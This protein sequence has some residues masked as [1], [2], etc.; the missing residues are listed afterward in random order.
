MPREYVERVLKAQ[1]YEVA[2]ETPLDDAPRLSKRLDNRVLIKREDLQSVFSFKLRGA[3]NKIAGL[4]DAERARGVI[5][6]SAGNHAQ[7]VALAAAKLGVD[8]LIVMPETTPAIKS[9]AV[10]ALGARAVLHGSSYD[11][12]KQHALEI[13]DEE[14]RVFVHPFDDPDVIA[15]QGTIG[16]EILRQHGSDIHAIFEIFYQGKH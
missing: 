10:T 6:S 14:G 9:D 1:V 16:H 4:S 11:D 5:A 12:A 15:G 13:A 3:Y 7:G 8:A 2:E